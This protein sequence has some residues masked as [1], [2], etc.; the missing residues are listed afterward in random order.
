MDTRPLQRKDALPNEVVVERLKPC[1]GWQSGSAS[2]R[3]T[4]R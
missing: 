4:V 2:K 1:L 3:G